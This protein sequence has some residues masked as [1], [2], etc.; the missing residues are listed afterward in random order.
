MYFS[1]LHYNITNINIKIFTIMRLSILCKNTNKTCQLLE[2]SNK[3]ALGT[4]ALVALG[5]NPTFTPFNLVH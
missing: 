4:N 2:W 5:S 3:L 1:L